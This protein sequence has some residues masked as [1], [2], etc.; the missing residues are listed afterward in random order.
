MPWFTLPRVAELASQYS[1]KSADE[2]GNN[3]FRG[4]KSAAVDS[5]L[6]TMANAATLEDLRT[7]AQALDRVVMWNFWQVPDLFISNERVSYWDKFGLP[8]VRPQ[9]Y[10]IQSPID[11]QPAWPITTWWIKDA[12]QQ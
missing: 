8:A 3:N 5:L 6:L 10:T 7:A 2:K 12:A 4:V 11:E 9:Y 1:S